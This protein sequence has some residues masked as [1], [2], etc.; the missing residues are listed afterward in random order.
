MV[1]KGLNE[2][3]G[4]VLEYLQDAKVTVLTLYDY[5]IG[6]YFF[7][8]SFFFFFT[9]WFYRNMNKGREMIFLLQCGLLAGIVSSL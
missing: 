7:F 5:N 4:V 1:I 6:F 8:F 2:T 3:I 9:L